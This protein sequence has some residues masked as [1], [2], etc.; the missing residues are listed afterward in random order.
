MQPTPQTFYA[1][2]AVTQDLFIF[3]CCVQ[4]DFALNYVGVLIETYDLEQGLNTNNSFFACEGQ[5]QEII[6]LFVQNN[7]ITKDK[8]LRTSTI[9]HE[10]DKIFKGERKTP[11]V[12]VDGLDAHLHQHFELLKDSLP[13]HNLDVTNV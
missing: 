4:K 1:F 3:G 6:D 7:R 9:L 11:F 10:I 12:Y 2:L 8:L 13:N 5:P